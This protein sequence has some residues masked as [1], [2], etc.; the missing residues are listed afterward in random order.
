VLE[1]EKMK[2]LLISI[3]LLLVGCSEAEMNSS[4]T[5]SNE[6]W[7]MVK[8]SDNFRSKQDLEII[9]KVTKAIESKGLGYLDGHS[10]GRYQ[11]DFNY[12]D[13]NNFIKTKNEIDIVIK[14]NYPNLI[15]T[16]SKDYETIYE[17]L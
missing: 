10:S 6:L 7:V 17:K 5:D 11:L 12:I 14:S 15:Y 13:I 9:D 8:I 4:Q 3:L 2:Y 1:Q 16:I